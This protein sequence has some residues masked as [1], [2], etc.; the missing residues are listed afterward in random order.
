MKAKEWAEHNPGGGKRVIV[1]KE[2][3]GNGWLDILARADC[4][5]EVCTSTDILTVDEIKVRDR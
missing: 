4:R 5:V 2:L 1:T 3:P